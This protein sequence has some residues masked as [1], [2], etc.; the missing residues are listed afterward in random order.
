MGIGM[1]RYGLALAALLAAAP[2]VAAQDARVVTVRLQADY[3]T[4]DP[5]KMRDSNGYQMALSLY[6][7]LTALGEDGAP[8]PALAESWETDGTSVVFTLREGVTCSDGHALTA[9]DV[10]NSL[11]RM[12]APETNSPY[13]YRT[14]GTAGYTVTGDD[15]AR[16]VTFTTAEPFSDVLIGLAMPWASIVCPAGL[17][18]GHDLAVNPVGSGP[19]VLDA[20]NSVRADHYTLTARQDYA[21]GPEGA[22]T[23]DPGTPSG[24][25]YR[26]IANQTTAANELLGGGLDVSI[27]SGQDLQRLATNPDLNAQK[28][29]PFGMQF[30]FFHHGENHVTSDPLVRRAIAAAFDREAFTAAATFGNGVTAQSYVSDGVQ[31]F[32]T[33]VAELLPAFD[34]EAA[35]QSLIEA[36]F[37]VSSG[38]TRDGQPV[39]I[40]IVGVPTYQ[41]S[42]PEYLQAMLQQIGFQTSLRSIGI[43]EFSTVLS[44]D[45]WDVSAVAFGPPMPSPN[46]ITP[47]VTGDAGQGGSN[48]SGISN[49]EFEQAREAALAA[50][51]SGAERCEYWSTAQRALV[52]ELDILPLFGDVSSYFSQP[53]ITFGNFGPYVIDPI[54]IKVAE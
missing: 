4:L 42:G 28:V 32:D 16:A 3:D 30:M 24:I 2:S 45:D 18:E 27:I 10:A 50:D 53:G 46:T 48:F 12:G 41:N 11:T 5:A 36:G 54:S 7:R 31:C 8:V 26:V 34:V 9:S 38:V 43:E 20:A 17:A 22:A 21:W 51:P 33:G 14:T 47:F 29:T 44:G 37:D 13:A 35:R 49:A 39:E 19:F 1:G 25:V 6:D 40:R 15:A 52:S 23:S